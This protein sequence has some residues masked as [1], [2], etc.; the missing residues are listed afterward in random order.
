MPAENRLG[1]LESIGTR[2]NGARSPGRACVFL[3][4]DGT[5]SRESGYVNHPDRIELL[6]GAAGA[7]KNLNKKGVLA[8]LTTNQAGVGHGYFTEAVL[9]QIHRRLMELLAEKG[10]KLDAIYYAPTHPRASV[11]KYRSDN[12]EMRKPGIGMI[13]KACEKFRIDLSRSYVVGDKISD[14]EMAHRAGIKGVF[15][16]SGYGLGE[17]RYKRKEW[18]VKPDHIAED[19]KAAVEWILKDM[20]K[21]EKVHQAEK[22]RSRVKPQA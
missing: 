13:K 20:Q 21:V 1:S 14:V 2:R 15:V 22:S 18:K 8:I 17:Y 3:D 19:L 12:D 10:A 11:E 5:V 16:L 7:V 4:R 6:P 9:R